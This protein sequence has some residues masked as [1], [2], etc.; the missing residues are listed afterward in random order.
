[1]NHRRQLFI[2]FCSIMFQTS[3]GPIYYDFGDFSNYDQQLEI[4]VEGSNNQVLLSPGS[5]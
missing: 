5:G 4:N 2:Y 1:M 3:D